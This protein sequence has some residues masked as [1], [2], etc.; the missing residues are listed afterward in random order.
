MIE[1]DAEDWGGH[2]HVGTTVDDGHT[3]S[4]DRAEALR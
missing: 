2:V 1:W 3:V 4:E